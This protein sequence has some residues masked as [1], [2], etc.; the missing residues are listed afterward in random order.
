MFSLR[1]TTKIF[2]FQIG[3]KTGEKIGEK[4]GGTNVPTYVEE[5]THV[6]S[7]HGLVVF[8]FSLFVF[9]FFLWFLTFSVYPSISIFF[10]MLIVFDPLACVFFF[11]FGSVHTQIF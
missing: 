10:W 8:F 9:F 7:S 11:F 6:Q 4:E 5:K 2:S 1:P 3:E